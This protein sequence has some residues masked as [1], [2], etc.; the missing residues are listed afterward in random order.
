MSS[1]GAHIRSLGEVENGLKSAWKHYARLTTNASFC[2]RPLH[3]KEIFRNIYLC[4]AQVVYLEAIAFTMAEG[5]G[6]RGSAMVLDKKGKRI[7]GKLDA[8]W[9]LM[10][11]NKAFRS[12]VMVSEFDGQTPV[13]N[14][15]EECRKLPEGDMW[16]ENVWA[17]FREGKIYNELSS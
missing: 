8:M 12:K 9:K 13:N 11:E 17:D 2:S 1:C 10:P 4:F 14:Y 16:F 3:Y 7:H 6:S 15:W 5:V